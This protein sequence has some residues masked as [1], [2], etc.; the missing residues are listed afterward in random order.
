[1]KSHVGFQVLTG[2]VS[3]LVQSSWGTVHTKE[4]PSETANLTLLSLVDDSADVISTVTPLETVTC[5]FVLHDICNRQPSEVP[6]VVMSHD[7]MQH[8]RNI[9]MEIA[10]YHANGQAENSTVE[11]E[12]VQMAKHCGLT[13]A[14]SVKSTSHNPQAPRETGIGKSCRYYLARIQC[15]EH[16]RKQARLT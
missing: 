12:I 6:L 16:R 11:N 1:M 2:T 5:V 7:D 8:L 15:F 9:L 10:H 3:T 14:N 4:A 13:Q